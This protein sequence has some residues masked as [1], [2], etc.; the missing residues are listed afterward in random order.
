MVEKEIAE[1]LKAANREE[2]KQI[3]ASMYDEL[4][5]RVPD[6]ARLTR[7]RDEEKT[8]LVNADKLSIISRFLRESIVFAEFAPGDCRFGFEVAKR[9]KRVIGIDI[10]DQRNPIDHVPDN[11]ELIIYDGYDLSEVQSDSVDIVFSDQMIEHLHPEDTRLHF[12]LV[13]RILRPGG[14]YIFRT[15]H[16]LTGPH[17]ISA[18]FSDEPEGLHL[19][20]WT[21]WEL[22]KLLKQV[23]YSRFHTYWHKRGIS[24]RMPNIHFLLLERILSLLPG[25]IV[26][27]VTRRLIPSIYGIVIK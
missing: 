23:G 21:F 20:E 27:P 6:H 24:V 9:V 15:P 12:N 1:R 10:S 17:D 22:L 13:Q 25:R 19:K 5:A 2:R 7:R 4:F 14:K 8:R 16:A 18:H 26:R 11:F 3:Y